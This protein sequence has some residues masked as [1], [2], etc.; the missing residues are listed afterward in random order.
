M[1]LKSADEEFLDLES[2]IFPLYRIW[3]TGDCGILLL[4]PDLGDIFSVMMDDKE[5]ERCVS[6]I[7]QGNAEK[8]FLLI[9]EMA[10]LLYYAASGVLPF[11]RDG[12]RESGYRQ[13]PLSAYAQLPER[14]DGFISFILNARSRE[15]RDIMGNSIGGKN[16]IWFLDRS[17]ALE[18]NLGKRSA[19]ERDRAIEE[20]KNSPDYARFMEKA[21]KTAKRNAFWRIKGTII[22][23][24]VI[25]GIAVLSFAGSW[26]YR[27]LQPPV[28]AGLD[29]EAIIEALYDAQNNLDTQLLTDAVKGCHLPQEM[30]VTNL[31]VTSRTRVAYE[32]FNPV[33]N[34]EE[35]IE[36][37][38]PAIPDSSII[39]GVIVD[40]IT[41][42]DEDS[43]VA[44][45]TWYTPYPADE[46]QL[47]G[48]YVY[49]YHIQ[50]SF[51]FGWNKRG[52]WNITDS[53]ITIREE[54]GRE[55][56]EYLPPRSPGNSQQQ[57]P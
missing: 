6:S 23:V 56:V 51:E 2:G 22:T 33:I 57:M 41:E 35:W 28:T 38:K 45:V 21:E 36:A 15:M 25:L 44:D 42:I 11:A 52:W 43:F 26:L 17:S 30:E 20:T 12:I 5:K 47:P 9:T 4:P 39:Y 29:P 46:N 40:S 32:G 16:L 27:F 8:G 54:I 53:D 7:I 19:E 31:Y 34:A 14:T 50:Q 13:V 49:L 18:W 48:G 1:A 37:G 24:S 10:E 3:I 55:P